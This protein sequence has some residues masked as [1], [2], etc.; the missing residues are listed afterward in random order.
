MH[1]LGSIIHPHLR[2]G[3]EVVIHRPHSPTPLETWEVAADIATCTP[4]GTVPPTVNGIPIIKVT[5]LD[6]EL[7]RGLCRDFAEPETSR[8][9]LGYSIRGA[10]VI[11]L[12]PDGRIWIAHPTNQFCDYAATFP[13]GKIDAGETCKQAAVR[14]AFE[15]TGLLVELHSH[16][17]DSRRS[18]NYAR[19]YLGKRVSG[20]PS[21]MGWETQAVS[22]VPPHQ[23]RSVLNQPA[24]QVVADVVVARHSE[25]M[26]LLWG[27]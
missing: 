7:M 2:R 22:L 17:M 13:K 14:E 11:A 15:E 12:E 9:A 3:I 23:I 26:S 25:L 16:F 5:H 18:V 1:R 27:S 19:Y 4:N 10:G 8:R 20:C 6:D 24:D 21:Q